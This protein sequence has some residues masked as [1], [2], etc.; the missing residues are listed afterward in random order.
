M[1]CETVSYP[2]IIARQS[3][4]RKNDDVTRRLP[5]NSKLGPTRPQLYSDH[6]VFVLFSESRS[7]PPAAPE[8]RPP[9]RGAHTHADRHVSARYTRT[10]QSCV[11]DRR[12]HMPRPHWST[13][14]LRGI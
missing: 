2:G 7:W 10:P 8:S 9:P 5:P 12:V 14:F 11:T 6:A 4:A 1:R 13:H 3:V